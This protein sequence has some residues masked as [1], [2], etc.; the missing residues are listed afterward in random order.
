VVFILGYLG[1]VLA[2]DADAASLDVVETEEQPDDGAL[3]RPRL[4]HLREVTQRSKLKNKINHDGRAEPIWAR[5][6]GGGGDVPMPLSG[7]GAP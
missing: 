3:A 4:A 1:Y 2:V 5:G 7:R 6:G